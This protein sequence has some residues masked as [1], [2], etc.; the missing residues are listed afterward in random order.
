[1]IK[2]VFPHDFPKILFTLIMWISLVMIVLVI[3]SPVSLFSSVFTYY[4]FFV[5]FTAGVISYVTIIGWIR[6]R[7]FAPAFAIGIAIVV[8]GAVNDM[9]FISDVIETGLSSHITLFIYLIIYAMIFSGKT[10]QEFKL[11]MRLSEEIASVNENLENI[12][13]TRT[14]E[15]SEKSKELI[16]HREQLKSSNEVLQRE[17]KFRNRLFTII[18]HDVKGPIAYSYQ[19]LELILSKKLN[20]TEEEEMMKLLANSSRSTLTLLENLLAWVRSESGELKSMSVQFHIEKVIS[21]SKEL[22][23]I[24]LNDKHIDLTIDINKDASVYADKEHFR[25]IIRN[26]L[27]NAIKFTT[28]CGKIQI[29]GREDTNSGFTTIEVRDSGVGIPPSELKNLFSEF[30]ITSTR[31]TKN[32]KGSGIGLKLCKELVELNHGSIT[33]ESK[34]KE[35]TVFRVMLPMNNSIRG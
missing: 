8:F 34:V 15:L 22:F 3:V 4:M 11:S 16:K 21:E 25:L 35:G 7:A 23:D 18:A 31:G 10:Q 2:H 13:L 12:V 28:E 14:K 33:V 1:M 6:G 29:S 19:A 5:I 32:E 27:A 20:K 24:P 9:L 30:E 17:V 26:L